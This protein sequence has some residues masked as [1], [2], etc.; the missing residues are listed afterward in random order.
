[1]ALSR[2]FITVGAVGVAAFALIGAGASATFQDSVTA[3]QAINVGTLSLNIRPLAGSGTNVT[4]KSLSLT[5]IGP[6]ASTFS[7]TPVAFQVN[8]TGDITAKT[9][10]LGLSQTN[11]DANL[12]K[13]RVLITS[14]N[15]TASTP[16]N[17]TDVVYDGTIGDFTT[18]TMAGDLTAANTATSYDKYEISFKTADGAS[19]VNDDMGKSITPIVTVTYQG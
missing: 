3:A 8:N 10:Q 13:L 4:D 12:L 14:Y 9:Y 7:T 16:G 15:P 11:N 1:M 6:T 19:L 5:P 2:K 18:L 17:Y